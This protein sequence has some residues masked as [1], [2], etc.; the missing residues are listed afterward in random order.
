[1]IG[2][3]KIPIGLERVESE[4]LGKSCCAIPLFR[5][6]WL[7]S[8]GEAEAWFVSEMFVCVWLFGSKL[9]CH[10]N[11]YLLALKCAF[12]SGRSL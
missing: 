1:M 4:E 12:S 11:E 2:L 6:S 8:I 9:S 10:A 3:E 7:E 5:K